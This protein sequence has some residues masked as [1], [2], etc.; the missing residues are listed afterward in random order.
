MQ[1]APDAE[2]ER[3]AARCEALANSAG[4]AIEWIAGAKDLVR[5]DGPTMS[6][7]LRRDAI[8]ARRLAAA[9]RRPMCVSVFGPSQQG[10]SYLISSLARQGDKPATIRFAGETRG[11]AKDIN[12][13]GGKESTGLVTRFSIRPIAGLPG[14]PVACRM[15][16]QTDIVKILANAF[17][18]DFDRDTV[19]PLER[20]EVDAVLERAR[21]KAAQAPVDVLTE[22]D[23]YDLFEYF[24]RYFRNHPAHAALRPGPWREIEALA[25]RLPI[26]ER[27]ELFSLLWNRTPTMTATGVLLVSQLAQLGFPAE[28]FCP[29]AAIE[30][31]ARSIIDV[32]TMRGLGRDNG[33][34]IEVATREGGHASVPRA[35]LTALV[36]ELQLQLADKPFDFFDYTDLL[37]FPGA[38]AREKYNAE[39]AE[40]TA[41]ENLFMLFRRGKVA[42]LYQRYLAEQELTSMLLCLRDSNQEVRSVPGMVKDW[43]DSTHGATPEERK[44]RQTAL[45]LVFTMFDRE[46][47]TKAGSAGDTV[48]HWSI[49][50]DTTIK[51][52]LGLDH[53]WPRNW[54]PGRSFANT[55]WL[56]NP[57]VHDKGLLDYAGADGAMREVA[58]REPERLAALRAN[59]LRNEDVQRHFE[60]P[61]AAWDSAMKLNDGGIG[62][63]AERLAPVCNPALKR[64]Q[65]SAQA[66]DLGNRLAKRLE[67]YHVS[68]DLDAE[69]QKRRL[70]ARRAGREL[71]ACASAQAF[72][73]MLR[74]LQVEQDALADAFRRQTLEAAGGTAAV[75][76]PVG[77]R[78]GDDL[79]KD[80]EAM[81]ADTDPAP[82]P[83][84]VQDGP[85]DMADLL[86]SAAVAE[87]IDGMNRFAARP[88]LQELFRMSPEVAATL[89][90]QMVHASRR[91]GLRE[92][93]AATMRGSGYTERL[94]DRM[95]RQVMIAERAINDFVAW[96]GFAGTSED[97]RP[98]AGKDQHPVFAAVPAADEYPPLTETPSAYDATYYLDWATAFVR[99]VEDNVRDT[100]GGA[101]DIAA[102]ARLG[103]ILA[104]LRGAA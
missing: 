9:A 43:I 99:I 55:Y 39:R 11:F 82:P 20:A 26:A 64:V 102:N 93:I 38:R 10:K 29:M 22:D 40:A 27:M 87:W 57:E 63:I 46:F 91:L 103:R 83:L 42:Y 74:A 18:E 88:D 104:T 100:G 41:A 76:A 23:V 96:L 44:D 75:V 86:A 95:S 80:F 70:E 67:A 16:S 35:V 17:M 2:N 32:E 45:F 89:V 34:P 60:D 33:D 25:P 7:D 58:F 47:T 61:A 59:F 69:L 50:F 8:R 79:A 37:D 78:V 90:G 66:A 15:L 51:Q 56:R 62:R 73:L 5:E 30:P 48:E 68:G 81:F 13:A 84:P 21:A 36:A 65:V 4:E 19:M 72:G 97:T 53:D 31:K 52:Y 28:A 24:E 98:R 71:L 92:R 3:L 49:R 6:R 1:T 54:A 101:V 77:T 12:P 85:K 94:A 14:K